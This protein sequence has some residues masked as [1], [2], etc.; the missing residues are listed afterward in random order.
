MLAEDK[1]ERGL[2]NDSRVFSHGLLLSRREA[3]PSG[4]SKAG[5][6]R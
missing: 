1:G 6:L 4:A 3:R 2:F 5:L